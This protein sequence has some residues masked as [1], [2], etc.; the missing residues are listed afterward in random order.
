[1]DFGLTARE[2]LGQTKSIIQGLC[3]L[4]ANKKTAATATFYFFDK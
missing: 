4:S 1:M 3:F 2:K